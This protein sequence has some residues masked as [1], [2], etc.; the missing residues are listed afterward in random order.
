[1]VSRCLICL[2]LVSSP[3]P[4]SAFGAE[5][6]TVSPEALKAMAAGVRQLALD[7]E[8]VG[9]EVL[10]LHQRKVVLHEAFGWSDLDRRTPLTRNTIVCVRSMTKPLVGTAIQMLIDEGKLSLT[11]PASKYLEVL[12]QR[13]V[14]RHH[15]RAIVDAHGGLPADTHQQATQRL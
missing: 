12:C 15:D 3:W 13:Q 14:S 10:V 5:P 7:D 8:A 9:A 1:M 11:D 4:V 2:V 6:V